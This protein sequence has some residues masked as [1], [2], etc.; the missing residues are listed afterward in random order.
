VR[1]RNDRNPEHQFQTGRLAFRRPFALPGS[2]IG[3]AYLVGY[4]LLDS[5]STIHPYAGYNITP[6]Y[7]PTGL[8]FVL[9]LA[10]GRRMIPY[11]FVAPLLADLIIRQLPFSWTLQLGI[12]AIIGS[13]YSLGLLFLMR[14]KTCFNLARFST[15]DLSL[16][17]GTAA[18]TVAFVASSYVGAMIAAGLVLVKDF[19]SASLR[20]WV[21]DMI[22][23]AVVAPFG[24][25]A[26]TRQPLLK[27]S[28]ETAAQFAAIVIALVVVFGF[29]VEQHFQLF[30]ILFL[31]IIWMAVRGGF[32]G[33]TVGILV[34]QLG[35]IIGVY[36]HSRTDVD[37]TAF[38]ALMLV[39]A[40]TGLVAGALVTERHRT[41]FQLRL[42]QDAR[43]RF[44]R[45]SSLGELAAAVAHEINQPLMAAG[46]YS[47]LVRDTL[48]RGETD[49]DT[50]ILEIAD[51]VAAQVERASNVVRRLQAL[52]RLDKS[53][54]APTPVDRIL[55]DALDQ[56]QPEL[57]RSG[58]GCRIILQSDL[59]PVKVDLLQIE[60]VILNLIRNAMEAMN[61][62]DPAEAMITI[63][64]KQVKSG[65]VE[66]SVRDTGPG[67]PEGLAAEEFP[68]FATTKALG[69]GIGL[70][71]S[72]TIIE[73]HGGQMTTGGDAQGT[74]VR[75]TL[76]AVTNP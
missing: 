71:L 11:L 1:I 36:L 20:F 58:I 43:A 32:Q 61:K 45:L 60:Q 67:F 12:T 63:E 34:V 4:V 6:W 3:A 54:Q 62:V 30:Y 70:S 9:V 46:T 10:F 35:L 51:K 18:A 57:N 40:I 25:M 41:E 55:N 2:A 24:L 53:Q 26:L 29:P 7:P 75:L 48:R 74:I 13:G 69:L 59:P 19:F 28:L 56:C 14:P 42:H 38:Q 65:G 5:I 64:A 73:A 37:V 22:G 33:V 76:P 68:R 23:I 15:R 49:R 72:R 66:L 50:S 17:L 27:L 8:S 16:L 47:R 39:L 52:V 31:P 44:A 21:G